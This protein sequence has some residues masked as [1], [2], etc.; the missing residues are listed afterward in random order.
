MGDEKGDGGAESGL[1]PEDYFL[2][3]DDLSGPTQLDGFPADIGRNSTMWGCGDL[4][5]ALCFGPNIRS[6]CHCI[7]MC[8]RSSLWFRSFGQHFHSTFALCL[9]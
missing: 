7:Y 9:N 3:P 5:V 2:A 8:V 4:N 1:D 6:P